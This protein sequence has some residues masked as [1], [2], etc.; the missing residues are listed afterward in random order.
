MTGSGALADGKITRPRGRPD[1]RHS[2]GQHQVLRVEPPGWGPC[3]IDCGFGHSSDTFFYQ[4]AGKLGIDR[5]A[6][7]AKQYGFG[8]R[9]G[10]DLPAR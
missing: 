9:T 6:Y 3:N 10:I 1:T 7:W 4:V 2:L 8:A 5:L